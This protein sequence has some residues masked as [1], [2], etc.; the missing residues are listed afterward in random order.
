[1]SIAGFSGSLLVP[2]IIRLGQQR[3]SVHH[4][5]T[6]A[7]ANSAIVLA[8]FAT[9]LWSASLK[10][11]TDFAVYV[12]MCFV[13]LHNSFRL[14]WTISALTFFCAPLLILL[15]WSKNIILI[16]RNGETQPLLMQPEPTS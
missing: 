10:V 13:I 5:T 6:M 2:E 1:M 3:H 8:F 14:F 12:G 11:A 16:V 4:D 9:P 7:L 15:H